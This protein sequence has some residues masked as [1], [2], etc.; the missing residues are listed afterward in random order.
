M[1]KKLILALFFISLFFFSCSLT[2]NIELS[3]LANLEKKQASL[4]VGVSNKNDVIGYLGEAI[5]KDHPD[6]NSWAYLE[7]LE[8]KNIFG[9]TKL[10]KN[11]I[12][13]LSFNERGV[14][15]DKRILNINDIKKLELDQD[16]TISKA[17]TDSFSSKFFGRVKKRFQNRNIN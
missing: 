5:L 14:L 2:P 17:S 11:N 13:L 12:L 4:T 1:K 15:S 9:K 6:N 7:I 16:I 3:G 8:G 10:I